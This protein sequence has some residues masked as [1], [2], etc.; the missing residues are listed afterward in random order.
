[1][2]IS[3]DVTRR[4][5]L[6]FLAVTRLVAAGFAGLITWLAPPGDEL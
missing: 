5:L 3:T 1:M 2:K 6:V 4:R